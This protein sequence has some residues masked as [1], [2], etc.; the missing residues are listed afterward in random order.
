MFCDCNVMNVADPRGATATPSGTLALHQ[1]YE[2]MKPEGFYWQYA[3]VELLHSA[4]RVCEN[5]T[6]PKEFLAG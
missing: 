6:G 5:A 2:S 3:C 1:A 4:V